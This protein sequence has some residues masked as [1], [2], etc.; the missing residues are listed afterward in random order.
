MKTIKAIVITFA[1]MLALSGIA[2][3]DVDVSAYRE[4]LSTGT[5]TASAMA[6][7]GHRVARASVDITMDTGDNG[8]GETTVMAGA[9]KYSGEPWGAYSESIITGMSFQDLVGTNTFT[10]TSGGKAAGLRDDLKIV[11]AKTNAEVTTVATVG[12]ES[13]WAGTL[14][15][16]G[17]YTSAVKMPKEASGEFS[18]EGDALAGTDDLTVLA[19][20]HASTLGGDTDDSKIVIDGNIGISAGVTVNGETATSTVDST[21][22]G[23]AKVN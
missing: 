14:V 9:S 7:D 6:N 3:A 13:L 4:L 12:G 23:K 1:V 10:A 22:K 19:Y 21:V 17:I 2:S 16:A 15:F 20:S 18:I 8:K 5:Q 11:K